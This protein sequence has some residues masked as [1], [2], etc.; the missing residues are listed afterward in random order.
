MAHFRNPAE[1][2]PGSNMPAFQ[3]KPEQL[4]T[5][6]AFVRGLTP[7]NADALSAAPA[8]AISGA[9]IYV[10]SSCDACHQVNGAGGKIGPPLNGLAARLPREWIAQ[11]VRNPASQTPGTTM[12]PFDLPARDSGLL[13]S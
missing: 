9:Q 2:R 4:E 6:A 1:V 8:D 11:H 12:P 10:A 13:V 5:L 3:W 7:E